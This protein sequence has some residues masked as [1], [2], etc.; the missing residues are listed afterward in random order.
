MISFWA[1]LKRY[2]PVLEGNNL[3][4]KLDIKYQ[5]FKIENV[6]EKYSKSFLGRVFY[7]FDDYLCNFGYKL[8]DNWEDD[9]NIENFGYLG[10]DP[11]FLEW[12][13]MK[14]FD[15]EKEIL[16]PFYLHMKTMFNG[17]P[18]FNLDNPISSIYNLL[19]FLCN[20]F[21]LNKVKMIEDESQF[22]RFVFAINKFS[23]NFS[24]SLTKKINDEKYYS[25]NGKSETQKH[26]VTFF[27]SRIQV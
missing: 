14:G 18:P 6:K 23:N 20:P 13:N 12:Q 21:Y 24:E 8:L 22:E 7:C 15:I 11:T 9:N 3:I 17:E 10:E 16:H 5:P 1:T 4:L 27:A 19:I 2:E 26:I 25:V